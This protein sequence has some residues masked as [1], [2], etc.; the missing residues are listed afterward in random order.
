[1]IMVDPQTDPGLDSLLQAWGLKLR[2]DV[3]YDPKYGFFGQSQV[4]VINNYPSHAVTADLTGQSTFFP[5]ARSI[6]Q[7]TPAP[8]GKTV[9]ALLTTSDASWGE[10]N[11]DQVKGQNA[12]YDEGQDNKGPLTF[13]YAVEASGGDKPARLVVLGN[14]TF[15]TNGTLTARIS[16][17]G[18]QSQV[19]SGNGLLFGNSL[20]WLAGQENLIA[21]PA[22]QPDTHPIFLTSEQSSF[23]FWSSFLF[24]PAAI[25]II[26]ILVWWRRR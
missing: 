2:N 12:K 7:V 17:G 8:T 26:G 11:F 13:A 6:Q 20:H 9:T 4:P 3:I 15:I 18:Q 1:M 16:V 19:Q 14:S 5:G 22:K 21:I 23:V 24:I 10:T 25:L